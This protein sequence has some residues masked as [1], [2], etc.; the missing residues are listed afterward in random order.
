MTTNVIPANLA[1]ARVG[2]VNG[3][4]DAHLDWSSIDWRQVED[5]VRRLRQRIFT[6]AREGD[7]RRV[8]SLQ[9]LMLGSRSNALLGVRRVTEVNVGRKTAGVDGR[10]VVSNALKAE[11]ADIVRGIIGKLTPLPVKRVYIP[12]QEESAEHSV[13]P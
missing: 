10:I 3:P 4:E 2:L 9:K 12:R 13:F 7:L 1:G 5:D 8:R 11:L 6:A